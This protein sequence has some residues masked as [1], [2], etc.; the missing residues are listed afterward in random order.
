MWLTCIPFPSSLY[1][2]LDVDIWLGL[3]KLSW[4]NE[5]NSQGNWTDTC[6]NMIELLSQYQKLLNFYIRKGCYCK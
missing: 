5:K 3:K 4:N 6:L 2:A 1:P